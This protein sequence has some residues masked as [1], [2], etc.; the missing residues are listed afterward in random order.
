MNK[1]I[2]LAI[3]MALIACIPSRAFPETNYSGT[4][5][6]KPKNPNLQGEILVQ[7]TGSALALEIIT[8]NNKNIHSSEIAASGALDGAE[9]KLAGDNGCTFSMHFHGK[10][11]DVENA[12][13][14]CRGPAGTNNDFQG[15]YAA[16]APKNVTTGSSKPAA[17]GDTVVRQCLVKGFHP[18]MTLHEASKVVDD[19]HL[20]DRLS[21]ET[22]EDIALHYCRFDKVTL[23]QH[24]MQAI[25]AIRQEHGQAHARQN[26]PEVQ[27][28]KL[29]LRKY[30]DFL[31]KDYDAVCLSRNA[32]FHVTPSL[33]A[34]L[35][36]NQG[37]TWKRFAKEFIDTYG[38]M[39]YSYSNKYTKGAYRYKNEQDGCEISIYQ[40]LSLDLKRPAGHHPAH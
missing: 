9:A 14:E 4:Y 34:L 23:R 3:A 32:T 15:K 31:N 11:L 20:Q 19:L 2:F 6:Y 1:N 36:N 26:L 39:M 10:T 8:V 38:V 13:P 35:F 33:S 21:D 24:L 16:I 25:D 5:A 28:N 29:R 22:T 12:T 30:L 40:D 17:S 18:R 7:Q 27:S 37:Y